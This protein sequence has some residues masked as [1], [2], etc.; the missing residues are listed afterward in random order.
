MKKLKEK[1]SFNI[2]F[3]LE[4]LRYMIQ[5]KES[6]YLS[7][8]VRAEYFTLI[9]HSI[10]MKALLKYIRKYNKIPGEAALKEGCQ[11]L[12]TSKAYVDLI[13]KEDIPNINQCISNLYNIPLKDNEAI[14]DSIYSFYAYVEMKALNEKMDFTDYNLYQDYQAKVS[15][16]IQNSKPVEE[17]SPLLMVGDTARRQLL[18]K[19]DPDVVPT[20]YWQLNS[21]SN[22]NGYSKGSIFVFLDRPK[23]R[24]TFSLINVSRGYLSMK[25]NV[26]YI[27]TENGKNQIME[28][29]VQS[30]LNK[31][32]MEMLSGDYDKLEKSHMRKYSRLG[33]EFVV[34]RVPA[35]VGDVNTIRGIIQQLEVKRGIKISILIVDYAAKLASLAKDKED[36]VRIN[37]VY[38]EL[39]NLA[40]ELGLEAIWTA[41]HVTREAAK[42]KATKY[43]DNDIASAI[44]II[45]NAQCIIGLNST[46]EEEAHNIQRC[47]IVMQRDGKPYGRCMFNVNLDTQRWQEFSKN[48]RKI[49]DETQGKEVDRMIKKDVSKERTNP[50]HSKEKA[51]KVKD[52]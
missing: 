43:E 2:D 41:Q 35:L 22:G 32:K 4:I 48:A 36:V 42:H 49:Y 33:V 3:Q 5:D 23:A 30:T 20:P 17:D 34:Q 47:E 21:L 16:I 44:S 51:A 6:V 39:D 28:R 26:L 9:E 37:N 19:V 18:R 8:K 31:T 27:D 12:L 24:K 52:I 11:E 1:F 7:S 38:I 29:M 25:K 14:R 50:N 15:K 10:I 40:Q 45:R 46:E 13:T